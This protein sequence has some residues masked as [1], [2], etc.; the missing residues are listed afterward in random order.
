MIAIAFMK[1]TGA[2]ELSP[3]KPTL[4]APLRTFGQIDDAR[5]QL[6]GLHIGGG[7][8]LEHVLKPR[9]VIASE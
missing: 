6:L 7:R 3:M 5:Q 2:A 9:P 4:V 8:G 1:L